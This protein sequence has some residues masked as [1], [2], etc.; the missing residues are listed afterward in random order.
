MSVVQSREVSTSQRFQM[1]Y[2]YGKINRENRICPLYGGCPLFG[3]SA[4]RG[5]TL[6]DDETKSP[7]EFE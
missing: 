6:I 5:F 2:L 1:Y 7:E 3:G 4:I